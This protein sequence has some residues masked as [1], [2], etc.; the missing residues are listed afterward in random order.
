M[1]FNDCDDYCSCG[2]LVLPKFS[3]WFSVDL[4]STNKTDL[5]FCKRFTEQV[6]RIY[7]V[8]LSNSSNF[9]V[10]PKKVTR[11]QP[12]IAIVFKKPIQQNDEVRVE[13]KTGNQPCMP[14]EV[15]LENPHTT[16]LRIPGTQ[17]N[18]I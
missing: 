6:V 7:N 4:R 17:I 18:Q 14:L 5:E 8:E 16:I 10:F 15:K 3:E 13:L 9:S 11:E 12:K 1:L 2:F